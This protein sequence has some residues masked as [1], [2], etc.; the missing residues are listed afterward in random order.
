VTRVLTRYLVYAGLLASGLD[1]P[2]TAQSLTAQ[3][4]LAKVHS[5]YAAL[6]SVHLVAERQEIA[7]GAGRP[8]A[9]T[10]ECELA[11]M[12]G[13][14]YYARFKMPNVE[15][16]VVSDGS[17]IWRALISAK[18][19]TKV[20]AAALEDAGDEEDSTSESPKDLHDVLE[21]ALLY[22]FISLAKT[23]R[24][25]AIAKEEDFK[26]GHT[27]LRGYLVRAHTEQSTFELLVD[28]QSFLV[29]RAKEKRKLPHG[30]LEATTIVKRLEVNQEVEAALFAFEPERNWT[31]VETLMLPGEQ[32][33]LLAG[34]R[35][36]NFTLMTL[37][38]ETVTLADLHGKVVVL[39]FWATWCGPCRAEMPS[40]ERLRAEFGGAVQFY[41]VNKEAA[42]TVQKF[43][44]GN[45]YHMPVLLDSKHEVFAR[46]GVRA[47]PALVIIGP[48]GVIRQ[49]FVGSRAESAL[50]K[51]IRAVLDGKA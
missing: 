10:S 28:Q 9:A 1:I 11:A 8:S 25:A 30:V 29:V 16:M 2:A 23:A 31:E 33:M 47:I 24:D 46:Y 12:P 45:N 44:G 41:G 32:H 43:V 50:R 37:D 35:A 39:D 51:A 36:I 19:W 5:A 26:L 7:S 42:P 6:K 34:D 20:S 3:Q 14:R 49:Q 18:K 27:K 15:A 40:I 48:D 13:N 38:G 17:N 21:D 22:H 4:L